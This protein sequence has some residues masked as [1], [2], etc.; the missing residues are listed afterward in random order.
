MVVGWAWTPGGSP[1]AV[2]VIGPLKP[3]AWWMMMSSNAAPPAEH[4]GTGRAGVLPV[5]G[6]DKEVRHRLADRQHVL[7]AG[8]AAAIAVLHQHAVLLLAAQVD[9]PGRVAQMA[10]EGVD[11]MAEIVQLGDAVALGVHHHEIRIGPPADAFA[12][13]LEGV[14]PGLGSSQTRTSRRR[15]RGR[16]G[17]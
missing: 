6:R 13:D 8:P 3:P 17:R 2:R 5:D 4:R 14:I 12:V 15:A 1:S 10:V 7:I 9:Q 11:A 16:S